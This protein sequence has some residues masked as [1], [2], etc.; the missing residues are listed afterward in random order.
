ME[1]NISNS[2][3]WWRGWDRKRETVRDTEL[4]H[5]P[6]RASGGL[7]S[8]NNS[9]SNQT[10]HTLTLLKKKTEICSF[11][12][13]HILNISQKASQT[14]TSVSFKNKC[15]TFASSWAVLRSVSDWFSLRHSL[16]TIQQV[17]VQTSILSYRLSTDV[18]SKIQQTTMKF[19]VTVLPFPLFYNLILLKTGTA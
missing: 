10:V 12:N 15:K 3:K 14:N 2:E 9:E 19:K 6:N 11:N 17:R 18:L 8:I 1:S 7:H 13:K 5:S 16:S 4:Q